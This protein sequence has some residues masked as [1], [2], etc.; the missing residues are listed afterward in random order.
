M[1]Y[2][3][4]PP[5]FT[6]GQ[7]TGVAAALNNLRD[8]VRAFSDPWT[9]YTPTVTASGTATSG[10]TQVGYYQQA[11]KLV[12]ARFQVSAP[13]SNL[14]SGTYRVALPVAAASTYSASAGTPVGDVYVEDAGIAGYFAI[15]R[16]VNASYLQAFYLGASSTVASAVGATAPFTFG[17]G[18]FITGQITYEAA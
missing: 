7:K 5:T 4:S 13:A 2:T 14:G 16:L 10:W 11:G 8:F 12:V 15:A 1:P 9:A 18:D 3:G 6:S 17:P